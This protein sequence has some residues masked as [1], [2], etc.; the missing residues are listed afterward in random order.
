M[1]ITYSDSDRF[2]DYEIK[3]DHIKGRFRTA[4]CLAI[5]VAHL[6]EAKTIW[7]VGMDGFTFYKGKKHFQHCYGSRQ[8]NL[9]YNH[10]KQRDDIVKKILDKLAAIVS[11]KI[12]TP[13]KYSRHYDS[14]VLFK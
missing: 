2:R 3:A 7:V 10:G 6:M 14:S 5:A 11:F 4:G 9:S 1:T 8:H 13:T 12:I